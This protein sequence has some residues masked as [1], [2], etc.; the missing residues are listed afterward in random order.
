MREVVSLINVPTWRL[1]I[2]YSFG[3][4]FRLFDAHVDPFSPEAGGAGAVFGVAHPRGEGCSVMVLP[5]GFEV[6]LVEVSGGQQG[7]QSLLLL[8]FSCLSLTP[9]QT[10][11]MAREGGKEAFVIW[12]IAAV[13]R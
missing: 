1:Q 12:L 6:M 4:L 11:H 8:P 9:D 2:F 7:K 10:N 3:P 13:R 5:G